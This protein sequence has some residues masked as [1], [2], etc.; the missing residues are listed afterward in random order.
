MSYDDNFYD[1]IWQ[2]CADS[3]GAICPVVWDLVRPYSVV[4]VGCGTA[5]FTREFRDRGARV[6]G[7]DGSKAK[8]IMISDNEF[9]QADFTQPIPV[10][11][12]F[13]MAISLEVAEHIPQ[14]MAHNFVSELC[15][16][17]PVVLFSAAIP[18]QGGEGHVNERW[19][20][21]WQWQFNKFGYKV[22]DVLRDQ[23]WTDDRVEY[24]YRQN[25]MFFVHPDECPEPLKPHL[26]DP[27]YGSMRK[28]H[29]IEWGKKMGVTFE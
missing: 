14:H 21:Y 4:D 29:P 16:L 24:W 26:T 11:E 22:A 17:A 20:D 2:G 9:I 3:A 8:G 5:H 27:E 15:R 28:V 6:I 1:A 7:L 23:F 10:D 25:I 19:P 12:R 13:N 18:F